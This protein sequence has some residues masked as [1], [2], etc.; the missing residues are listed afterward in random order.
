M[1]AQFFVRSIVSLTCPV[2]NTYPCKIKGWWIELA[3]S[4]MEAVL[5][6][7]VLIVGVVAG[8]G[9]GFLVYQGRISDLE[10]DLSTAESDL[11]EAQDDITSLQG[12]INT[13]NSSLLS[14]LAELADALA[15]S[16]SLQTQLEE[17][18]A[19]LT[20]GR[21]PV[22]H[23]G[24]WWIMEIVFNATTYTLTQNVTGEGPDYY[25][26]Y[27]EYDP[28]YQGRCNST[29]WIDKSMPISP[30]RS[31]G[32]SEYAYNNTTII[33]AYNITFYRIYYGGVPFPLIVGK[34]LNMT[35]S[36]N[37]TSKYDTTTYTYEYNMSFV[38]EVDTIE[39]VTVPAGTFTCFKVN[40]W[41][42]TTLDHVY[43][44]WYS[45]EAKTWVRYIDYTTTPETT[46]ELKDYSV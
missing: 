34:E 36:M 5:L 14:T 2:L 42:A 15:N 39:N 9:G 12:R 27:S 46:A 13:L 32:H 45:D 11:A 22:L 16:A 29:D 30:V 3:V 41:N 35:E 26:V 1:R 4:R 19:E 40:L 31:E 23:V 43:T 33:Y 21:V 6:I 37:Y 10:S 8:F 24:D 28:P 18:Q 7:V 20:P 25:I 44:M 17:C 38:F